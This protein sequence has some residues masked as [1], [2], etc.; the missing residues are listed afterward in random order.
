MK[1]QVY[2]R[3]NIKKGRLPFEVVNSKPSK[4][5]LML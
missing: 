1:L 4:E 3:K 5:L 2:T